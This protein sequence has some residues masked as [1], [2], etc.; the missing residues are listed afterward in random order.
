MFLIIIIIN[1]SSQFVNF[2]YL[3]FDNL[4]HLILFIIMHL[5]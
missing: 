1:L 4:N 5:N 2:K 3:N